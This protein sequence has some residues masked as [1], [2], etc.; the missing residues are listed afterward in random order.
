MVVILP[1]FPLLTPYHGLQSVVVLLEHRDSLY[2]KPEIE[3][4]HIPLDAGLTVEHRR[5]AGGEKVAFTKLSQLL[6]IALALAS[7]PTKSMSCTCMY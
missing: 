7:T 3:E 4:V 6:P 5:V 1:L 2:T